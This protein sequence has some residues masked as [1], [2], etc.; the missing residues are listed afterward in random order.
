MDQVDEGQCTVQRSTE[1]SLPRRKR[2][3]RTVPL[4]PLYQRWSDSDIAGSPTRTGEQPRGHTGP[5]K[6]SPQAVK[7]RSAVVGHLPLAYRHVS[8]KADVE[9]K[10]R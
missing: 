4:A 1:S 3:A 9:R 5:A 10:L 8:A 2:G 6:Q 7:P